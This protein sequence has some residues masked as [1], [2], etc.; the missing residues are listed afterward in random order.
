ME[1]TAL[2]QCLLEMAGDIKP[3]IISIASTSDVFAG[4]ES[5]RGQVR[6]FNNLLNRIAMAADG[7]VVLTSHPSLTGIN[8]GSGISGTTQWHNGPRARAVMSGVKPSDGEPR[9]DDLRKIEFHKNQ[10]G[11]IEATIYVRWQ[12]GLFLPV[13]AAAASE[14]ER[15]AERMRR[16]ETVFLELLRRYT[17]QGQRLSPYQS[18]TG[19]A[20]RFA[21]DPAAAGLTYKDFQAAQQR[22]LNAERITIESDGP[23][24]KSRDR[25]VIK[26]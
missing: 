16:A 22:L 21:R 18:S 23:P 2:Y 25:L 1:P 13:T 20:S 9:D 4:N 19:A 11:R 6:Q 14:A 15:E 10:Y 12:N 5:D 24:S 3:R 17:A 7:T 8:T 26:G